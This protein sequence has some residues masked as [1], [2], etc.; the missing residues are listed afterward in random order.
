MID[1]EIRKQAAKNGRKAVKRLK[2]TNLILAVLIIVLIGIRIG[3]GVT[4]RDARTFTTEK[5]TTEPDNRTAI[6]NNLL[7]DYELYGM[8][9]EEIADLLGTADGETEDE[10]VYAL[11]ESDT[12]FDAQ[13]EQLVLYFRDGLVENYEITTE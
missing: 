11:G 3:Y 9:R 7:S 5:W 12:L 1:N 4:H 10:L 6:V 2:W 13:E 8:T